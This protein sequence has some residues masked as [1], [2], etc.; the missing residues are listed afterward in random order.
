MTIDLTTEPL[1]TGPDGKPS[2]LRTS[3]RRAGDPGD[4]ARGGEGRDVP[5]QYADVFAGDER[6]QQAAGARGRPLRLGSRLDLHPQ[7]AVLR[8][9][10]DEPAPL[11]R[12]RGARVLALLGDSVTT[13]HIS[14]A[15]SIKADSPPGST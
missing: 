8:G 12:H 4:D 13:D 11:G 7:A 10:D 5:Q 14:P 2:L 6:W 15:G 9:H 3:G 1:G